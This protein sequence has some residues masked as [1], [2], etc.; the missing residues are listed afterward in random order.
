MS[1]CNRGAS[2]CDRSMQSLQLQCQCQCIRY[3]VQA[4]EPILGQLDRSSMHIS[5]MNIRS[6]GSA[7]CNLNA[8]TVVLMSDVI[9]T[10]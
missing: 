6:S 3:A 2:A 7:D 1:A 8:D 10:M 4:H 5:S 9:V